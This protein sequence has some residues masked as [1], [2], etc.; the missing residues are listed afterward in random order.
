MLHHVGKALR[1]RSSPGQWKLYD[2]IPAIGNFTLGSFTTLYK[3]IDSVS[4]PVHEA[5]VT[6]VLEAGKDAP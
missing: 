4:Q 3:E 6:S 5:I 2:T 1:M